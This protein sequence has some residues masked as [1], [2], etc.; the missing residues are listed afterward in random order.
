MDKV[1]KMEAGALKAKESALLKGRLYFWPKAPLNLVRDQ[2]PRL[3]YLEG[4]NLMIHGAYLLKELFGE[5]CTYKTKG[6]AARYIKRWFW[7][8]TH[9]SREPMRNFAWLHRRHEE[10]ILSY[11]DP[12]SITGQLK[13]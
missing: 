5:L 13:P 7:W 4:L 8:A 2:K 11:F 9:S 6:W 3:G 1:G 12:T 10:G